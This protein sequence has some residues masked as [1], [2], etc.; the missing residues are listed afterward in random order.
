M[1]N[2]ASPVGVASPQVSSGAALGW[3]PEAGGPDLKV[4]A[5]VCFEMKSPVVVGKSGTYRLL[6]S[7]SLKIFET[8]S[9]CWRRTQRGYL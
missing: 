6:S 1:V 9:T 3:L 5:H 8:K 4:L 2:D 7:S